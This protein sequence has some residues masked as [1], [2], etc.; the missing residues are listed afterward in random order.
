MEW[1]SVTL[2]THHEM[3]S[4]A[5]VV[6]QNLP[7][8]RRYRE[9]VGSLYAMTCTRPDLSWVLTKLSQHLENPDNSNWIMLKHVLQYVKVQ[10]IL[11]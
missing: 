6:E 9:V 11:H 10:Q 2:G 5:N 1:I 3:K 4:L 8:Q 7:D